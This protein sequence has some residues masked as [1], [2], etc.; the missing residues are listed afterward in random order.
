MVAS[1]EPHRPDDK[2]TFLP[3]QELIREVYRARFFDD[4]A[5][6]NRAG[7]GVGTD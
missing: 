7:S 5:A 1:I 4:R 2:I 6:G 3:F